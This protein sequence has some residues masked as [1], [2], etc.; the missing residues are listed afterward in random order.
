[1]PPLHDVAVR[2]LGVPMDLG[3]QRRGV[4]MGPSALRYA[5]LQARL[6]RMGFEV[7][8]GGNIDVP[9]PEETAEDEAVQDIN[10]GRARHLQAVRAVCAAIYEA[11]ERCVADNQ[12]PIFLGGDHSIALGTVG[13]VS[14]T[15]TTGVIWIDAH[16]DF[17]TPNTSPSGNLHGMPL[18]HLV[19]LGI[20]ELRD[21]GRPG[22]KVDPHHVALIGLRN[23]DRGERQLLREMGIRAYT[24]RDIDERGLAAIARETIIHVAGLPRVHV[25]LDMDS[26]DP[27]VAPGVGTPVQGGLNYREAHLLM[28]MLSE[29]RK[30]TSLDI[31]EI[32]PIL[33][34]GNQTAELAVELAASLLGAKIL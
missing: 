29:S 19:G 10:G 23:V 20:P 14:A 32:N 6:R 27:R 30:I 25:S 8:D 7:E 9:A 24:M 4:D 26:L 5:G 33:D 2:I 1:M 21:V 13:G 3:Q 18:S 34:N 22:A 28:E 15:T 12:F 16:A 31:V 17:N 11:A